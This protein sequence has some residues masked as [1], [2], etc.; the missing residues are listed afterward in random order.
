VASGG[1]LLVDIVDHVAVLTLNEPE[2][3]SPLSPAL[4]SALTRTLQSLTGEDSCRV[5]VLTGAGRGFC[6]GADLRRM[7][8]TPR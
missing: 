6:A 5:V 1:P 8:V 3:R 2:R 4:V 7:A